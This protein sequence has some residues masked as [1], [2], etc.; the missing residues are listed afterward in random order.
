MYSYVTSMDAGFLPIVW[1][2]CLSLAPTPAGDKPPRYNPLSAPLWIPAF[3][4]NTYG[5][6]QAT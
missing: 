4:G 2:Y 6:A 3:A 1:R 5:L